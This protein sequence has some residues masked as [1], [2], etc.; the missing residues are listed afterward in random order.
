M[1]LFKSY[2]TTN[3]D[4]QF[5]LGLYVNYK[6]SV[7]LLGWLM[8]VTGLFWTHSTFI[9]GRNQTI[10]T[11]AQQYKNKKKTQSCLESQFSVRCKNL[12]NKQD[13]IKKVHAWLDFSVNCKE[14][15]MS[16]FIY[17]ECILYIGTKTW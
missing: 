5:Y 10:T 8:Y 17:S 14:E 4:F 2:L 3:L 6:M 1:L 16:C 12:C 7:A 11:A 9:E 13:V 15:N